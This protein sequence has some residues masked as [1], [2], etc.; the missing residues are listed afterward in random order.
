LK[1][2]E[3]LEKERLSPLQSTV[4]NFLVAM[5]PSSFSKEIKK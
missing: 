2:G 1:S 5:A 4:V 3:N